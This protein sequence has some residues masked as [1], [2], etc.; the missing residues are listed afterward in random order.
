MDRE[1]ILI[2]IAC[3]LAVLIIFKVTSDLAT[4]DPLQQA[5][6]QL[7]ESQQWFYWRDRGFFGN[8]TYCLEIKNLLSQIHSPQGLQLAPPNSWATTDF[9][10]KSDPGK[11]FDLEGTLF[12]KNDPRTS[13]RCGAFAENDNGYWGLYCAEAVSQN[14]TVLVNVMRRASEEIAN[15][16]SNDQWVFDGWRYKNFS[17]YR[18]GDMDDICKTSTSG[19]FCSGRWS[20]PGFESLWLY[21]TYSSNFF[22]LGVQLSAG[23]H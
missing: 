18:R 21:S 10:R 2:F 7:P 11:V 8:E 19:A 23:S 14:H 15:C 16:L 5:T 9:L 3:A 17:G 12:V 13:A 4:N 6:E 20:K 22:Y 1:R